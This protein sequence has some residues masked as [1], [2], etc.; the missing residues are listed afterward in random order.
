MVRIPIN[1]KIYKT[2][3][4]SL[5]SLFLSL[6]IF[7]FM[8]GAFELYY[9]ITDYDEYIFIHPDVLESHPVLG[10]DNKNNAKE[11]CDIQLHDKSFK[12][13]QY[14]IEDGIRVTPGNHDSNDKFVA[15]FGCSCTFGWGC[16]D[17]ETFPARLRRYFPEYN[18][19]NFGVCSSA[20]QHMYWKLKSGKVK[21]TIKEKEGFGIYLFYGFHPARVEM[22]LWPFYAYEFPY[23]E[24]NSTTDDLEYIGRIGEL[25]PYQRFIYNILRKSNTLKHHKFHFPFYTKALMEK[26]VDHLHVSKQY[27]INSFEKARFVVFI[28]SKKRDFPRMDIF[29]S[30]LQQR[31]I[32]YHVCRQEYFDKLESKGADITTYPD[33]HYTPLV[34]EMLAEEFYSSYD[35]VNTEITIK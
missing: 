10:V 32:E 6:L 27:F 4:Q 2:I 9:Y 3:I 26:C 30:M 17:D 7:I 33:G 11:I 24:Y 35:D 34:Q 21:N 29:I 22:S 25:H 20:T 14:T 1:N 18:V 19:Y 28:P 8:V 12:K 31:Q 13:I 5:V 16:N 23:Y 15:V